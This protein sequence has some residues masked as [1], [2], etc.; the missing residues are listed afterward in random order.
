MT[1]VSRR[2][3][4]GHRVWACI[5]VSLMAM[6]SARADLYEFNNGGSIV[7]EGSR[8]DD[9]VTISLAGRSF[10]FLVTDFRRIVPTEDFST[11][12]AK[13]LAEVGAGSVADRHASAL[14]ALER[15]HVEEAV[16]LIKETA[17][18]HHND[19]RA[20]RLLALINAIQ[21]PKGD[22]ETARFESALNAEFDAIR[23]P[24]LLFLHQN[25]E[26][27]ARRKAEFL[28][29]IVL[30]FHLEFGLRDVALELPLARMV[31]VE[32]GKRSDY[33]AFLKSQN[34]GAFDATNG[35]YHPTFRTMI[36]YQSTLKSGIAPVPA[37]KKTLGDPTFQD[38]QRRTLL[39]TSQKLAEDLG[40]AAHEMIH[41]LVSES[42]LLGEPGNAPLWLHEGLAM[43]YEFIEG[44]RWAGINRVQEYRLRDW[45]NL[46]K[47]PDLGGVLNDKGFGK[48][49]KAE[50]YAKS[51]ALVYYLRAAQ[52]REFQDYLDRLRLPRFAEE[53]N[54]GQKSIE[55]FR[56][57][58]GT[59]L[60]PLERAW[61]EAI[62]KVSL[63]EESEPKL[64]PKI[65]TSRN[66]S[67]NRD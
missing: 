26:L 16:Q 3:R 31:C 42:G 51:W 67:S 18:I 45:R 4:F 30:A 35:F 44:G 32:W 52:P 37:D 6:A 9:V 11:A 27:A 38:A 36:S 61:W 59:D 39:K 43:Q 60:N 29:R 24:N 12:W 64:I 63:A 17:K 2:P 34:A 56:E 8:D 65:E 57:T 22:S 15:G 14:W 10:T 62:S 41:L 47:R 33:V 54:P 48:G 21:S 58:Y 55:L 53:G 66:R 46:A 23:T 50:A 5:A 49:Y 7:A 19:P 20:A 28:E 40:T 25:N 13:R 1:N